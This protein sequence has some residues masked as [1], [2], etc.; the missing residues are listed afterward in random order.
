M[1]RK[2]CSIF[3]ATMI[4]SGIALGYSGGSG[5]ED[6]PYLISS[7]ADLE[8]LGNTS[9]D[10]GKY[11]EVTQN[12][13]LTG[14]SNIRIG[15]SSTTP[16][17]GYF[18]GDGKTI[19]NYTFT[20]AVDYGALF[21]YINASAVIE[22]VKMTNVNVNT[23]SGKYA[24]A[25]VGNNYG[26]VEGCTAAGSVTGSNYSGGLV[27]RNYGTIDSCGSSVVLSSQSR[28]GCITSYSGTGAT[29]N[30]CL[31]DGSVT[32]LDRI[33]GI[34]G[35]NIG[36]I[37]NCY[38]GASVTGTD[39]VG[40]IAGST[41]TGNITNSF[42]YG[43]VTGTLYKG[44]FIG[45]RVSGGATGCFFDSETTAP[46]TAVGRGASTGITGKTTAQMQTEATFIDAG[47]DFVTTWWIIP[48]HYPLLEW[49]QKTRVISLVGNLDFGGVDVGGSAQ[50]SLTI[51][52]EGNSDLTVTEISYPAG[53]SGAWSGLIEAGRSQVVT[54][55]F[56]PTA[57]QT[58]GGTI[59]VTSDKTAGE[60]TIECAGIGI[61]G[62]IRLTGNMSYGDVIVSSTLGKTLT[63]NND[64]TGP[65]VVSGISYPAGFSGSWSGSIA[66]GASQA[67]T[68]TF[69]PVSVA[70][71]GGTIT[72]NSGAVSGTATTVCSGT[73]IAQTRVIS[74]SGDTAFGDVDINSTSQR[75]ITVQNTGNTT[76]TVSGISY[77]AGF[78]GVWSGTIAAGGSQA[79][80]VTFA[81]TAAQTY[82]GTITVA[83]DKTAGENTKAASGT[84]VGGIIRLT[85]PLEFGNVVVGDTVQR[86]L[87]IYNDGN[88]TLTVTG[89]TYPNA[90][91]T[92]AWSGTIA[93][94]GSQAVTVTFAP[95]VESNYNGTITVASNAKSG[96]NQSS[97]IAAA[98]PET[99]IISLTGNMSFGDVVIGSTSQRTLTIVNSGNRPLSVSSISYPAG[100]SGA[101]SGTVAAGGS[102]PV[103]VTFSPSAA[104]SYGG[105]ITVNSNK[106]SGTNT[107]SCLGTGLAQT[108]VI[109]L[110]GN[111]I[112]ADTVS[113]QTTQQTLTIRNT[114]NSTLT[115]SGITYPDM[116]SGAWSGTIAAGG[117]HAVTVTFAPTVLGNYGGPIT[118]NSDA[119][120]GS[121]VAV[122]WGVGID[123]TIRLSG[124]LAF[125]K[126]DVNTTATRTLTIY[127]DGNRA[128]AVSGISYP[129]GFSGAWSGTIAAGG[130]QAVTV[131]FAP[132]SEQSYSGTITVA[133]DKTLG[134]NSIACS[135]IGSG[136]IVALSG[137]MSFGDVI[138]S[139][140]ANS[141]L[142]ISNNGTGP[143]V[144]SAINYPAGFSGNWSGGEIAEG[145]S[146]NV[147]V[148]F[149]PIAAQSYTGMITVVSNATSGTNT[150]AC[151]GV[152]I[153]RVIAISGD[154]AFGDVDINE[155]SQKTFT[156][157]N[158][159]NRPLDINFILYPNGFTGDW[160]S[161]QIAA[162]GQK[163]INVTFA[164]TAA[165]FY[166][167]TIVVISDST[168]GDN[169]I[170]ASGDG[171]DRVIALT[172]T[173]SFGNV[174]VSSSSQLTFTIANSGNRALNVTSISY[175][176]GFSG[177]W[178][179]MIAAGSQQTV[180]VTF[181][182]TAAQSYDGTITVNTDT[183]S[184]SNTIACS[185]VGIG[186]IIRLSGTLSFGS[187][188]VN[189][190][191]QLAY[192]IHNDGTGPLEVSGINYPAGFSGSWSGTIAAGASQAVT[193]TFA[194]TA[195]QSYSGNVVVSSDAVS[196]TNTI[197]CSGV[198]SGGIIRL[199]GNMAFAETVINQTRTSTLTIYN[200]GTG[201]LAVSGIDY[202]AGF[203]GNWSSGTI[204][205]GASKAVTVTFA[206]TATQSYSGTITVNSDATSGTNT[207]ACSGQGINRA[208][209]LSLT[210]A[211]LGDVD[212]NTSAQTTLTIQNTG[213]RTLTVTGISYPAGFTGNWS[214]GTIAAGA[215]KAVTVTFV[216]TAAQSYGGTITVAS[217]KTEGTNTIAISGY[218]VTRIVSVSG[219]LS[220]GLTSI[221]QTPG[222]TMTIQNTGNRALTVSGISYPAG[223]GGNWSG[224]AIAAGASKDVTV[225]F[226]PTEAKT[227]SGTITVNSDATSG[228]AAIDCFGFVLAGDGT[229][230][231]PYQI[232]TDYHLDAVNNDLAA[233]YILMNDID[234]SGTT[235]A[236]AVIAADQDNTT[237]D[238][239]GA[240]FS[241]LFDGNGHKITGL[242]IDTTDMI[243]HYLGLFGQVGTGGSVVSLSV[244]GVNITTGNDSRFI[245]ALCG[246]NDAGLIANS[247]A[248]GIISGDVVTL[249]LGG[250]CGYNTGIILASCSA[251]DVISG[252]NSLDTG[253]LCGTN[254][255]SIADCYAT[256]T[257]TGK[258]YVGG[259]CGYNYYGIITTSYARGD[260]AGE[261]FVGGLC[262]HDYN[263]VANSFWD[264]QTSGQ[265]TSAGG[266][267][268]STAEMVD[269][270]TFTA[271]GWDFA[272][273]TANGTNDIWTDRGGDNYP[274]LSWQ[275]FETADLNSD[276]LVDD[277]DMM[278]LAGQWLE[279]AS[280]LA[281][282]INN[283]GVVD[284]LD[285]AVMAG[286]WLGGVE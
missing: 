234:I 225:T 168:S 195:A 220:F 77:P 187:V 29:I 157:S 106:T 200:D 92:G 212:I 232:S 5:T 145:A 250:L 279:E 149:S 150:I 141:T 248:A 100:F 4:L 58:Y 107:V 273:E 118:V 56:A 140:T 211:A 154:L 90:V 121:N 61:G 177:A 88:R 215:S 32:G 25:L 247:Y 37:S 170:A 21:G 67:V 260:V 102:Q 285:F 241:G 284:L 198:G 231:N 167:G 104:Q 41:A 238:F 221:G 264:M 230:D 227:Y 274:S 171:V 178:S 179:G 35:E 165:E 282:D 240:P 125:G 48:S 79:V 105:T 133:S 68:V 183:T 278:I 173:L 263:T 44:A 86:T 24:A 123:R 94:R 113:G 82:S 158:T 205:S 52:N 65:L 148:T 186:G 194:P 199:A 13:D 146:K 74:I 89:I 57:A 277:A 60:N 33:G 15:T 265:N 281:G 130:S 126:V 85:S 219:N 266:I 3:L 272:G 55:T 169:T 81:P 38:S 190:T 73:G 180:N 226:A 182:P 267:G 172:G 12:I 243:S 245:G 99:R 76:L 164:P 188:N 202:P 80:T 120:S 204:A 286:Q 53:F 251:V 254:E 45:D 19:S 151:S 42:S 109:S 222:L 161:G 210:T 258:S 242:T 72:V 114:G 185:G 127:N 270:A 275:I 119:T 115:V 78:S 131:T 181:A 117:S 237:T 175:P 64:G 16:F 160:D 209:S 216:P 20:N 66:A 256:R 9:A 174:N 39:K 95:T 111:M 191:S 176:T 137:N 280:G 40:G 276:T 203:S 63:I 193:V 43:V 217:N 249:S 49:E 17:S 96:T 244:T 87:T 159:G 2:I 166:I 83:S 143:M 246:Y 201:P 70:S 129:A 184:G 1:L 91:F 122:S 271:A 46:L 257:V 214:S 62:I 27:A 192:T 36:N 197:A 261:D 11:F 97:V 71:Y 30:K 153:N 163:V 255:G 233:F 116:F 112:F 136:G 213:N 268:K 132:T 84:G 224:G 189:A 253:G 207:V 93:A 152:G 252:Y 283:D 162:G 128:L 51:Y 218:G 147:I 31:A 10:W 22:G 138:V 26:T 6:S 155:T 50:T 47:W 235:Y 75:Q 259:L 208:I 142:T 206:P 262:G 54:V 196:G 134:D 239:D 8:L 7:A 98:G 236:S 144:V 18:D 156:I 228:L 69:A 101:W 223:F 59:T 28:G 124:D 103:T 269:A 229:E 110:E 14:Y 108:R 139:L 23:V 135:G 34:V